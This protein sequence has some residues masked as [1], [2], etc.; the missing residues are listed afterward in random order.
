MIIV[1]TLTGVAGAAVDA[2]ALVPGAEHVPRDEVV[3]VHLQ[4]VAPRHDGNLLKA[5]VKYE[6]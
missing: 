5:T 1:K 2:A 4:A 6:C 3:H